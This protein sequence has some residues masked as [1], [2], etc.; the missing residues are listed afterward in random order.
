MKHTETTHQPPAIARTTTLLR[1]FGSAGLTLLLLYAVFRT[2]SIESLLELAAGIHLPLLILYLGISLTALLLRAVRY[3]MIIHDSL[4][5]SA[6]TNELSFSGALVV[7]SIRNALVDFLPARLGELSFFYVLNR[8]R[9]RFS[10]ALSAFGI[11]IALDVAVL[12]LLMLVAV[13]YRACCAANGASEGLLNGLDVSAL[14]VAGMALL[15]ICFFVMTRLDWF[16]RQATEVLRYLS[17]P[18]RSYQTVQKG[19]LFAEDLSEQLRHVR[20]QQRLLLF[21]SITI[22]LRIAKYG[23]LYVLLLSVLHPLGIGAAQI[24][25]LIT[26]IAFVL[27]EASASLPVSGLMG[28]GAYEGAWSLVFLSNNVQI[29]SVPGVILLVHLITQV[30]GYFLGLLGL[31]GFLIKE[32]SN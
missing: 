9:I 12:I 8:Y 20:K 2:Q 15:A 10:S 31:F 23:S 17:Y 19:I 32:R 30:V 22:L 21:V 26:T 25:P 4:D 7:T 5:D 29:P 6:D 24:D 1:F 27:A 13:A 16:A 3:R 28:F 11:C 18:L 14:T